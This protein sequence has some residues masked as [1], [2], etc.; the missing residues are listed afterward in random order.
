MFVITSTSAGA[1]ERCGTDAI[2]RESSR[3]RGFSPCAARRR[4]DV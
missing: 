4:G 1:Q 3:A 2:S